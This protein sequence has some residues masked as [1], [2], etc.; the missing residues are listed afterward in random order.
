LVFWESDGKTVTVSSG[1]KLSR[2]LRESI[3]RGL[4]GMECLAGIPASVG[5][6]LKNNA[7][8]VGGAITDTLQKILVLDG[9]LKTKW[10]DKK[11][12]D[13]GYRS[14]YW[15]G[16]GVILKAVFNF[17]KSSHGKVRENTRDL[18]LEK[19]SKQ[20]CEKK[21]LGCVFK[22]PEPSTQAAWELIDAAGMRGQK[23]GGAVVSEKHANFIVNEN[24][25]TSGDVKELISW[26]KR[27]VKEKF[28]IELEEEI[29]VI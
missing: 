27:R 28:N 5:G 19:F 8:S 4:S 16:G 1:V 29:E 10:I 22:N 20:P 24:N 13:F 18:L 2:L 6:A 3:S 15:D 17:R 21:T 26:T 12:V 9:S 23:A 7:S 14:F 11:E 25:A